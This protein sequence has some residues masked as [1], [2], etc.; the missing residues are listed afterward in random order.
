MTNIVL[1]VNFSL[2]SLPCLVNFQET[3]KKAK[4][5]EDSFP[6]KFSGMYSKF[7][8]AV[9]IKSNFADLKNVLELQKT[10]ICMSGTAT[11]RSITQSLRHL[12]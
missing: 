4:I 8:N 5:S 1:Q 10:L 7:G 11:K 9:T 6:T 12:T 2:L 3:V